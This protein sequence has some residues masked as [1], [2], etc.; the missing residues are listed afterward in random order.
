MTIRPGT[1]VAIEFDRLECRDQYNRV[2]EMQQALY[3]AARIMDAIAAERF[4]RQEALS[5]TYFASEAL[6]Y[7][8]DG[9]AEDAT[10]FMQKLCASIP[11]YPAF[12]ETEDEVKG[13]HNADHA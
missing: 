3:H 1:R 9:L 2:E 4:D 12:F 11:E 8:A 13:G 6:H 10:D 7:M 5:V